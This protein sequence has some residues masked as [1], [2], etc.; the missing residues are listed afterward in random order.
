M[1]QPIVERMLAQRVDG[2]VLA[3]PTPGDFLVDFIV[4]TGL[5]PVM[6]NRADESGR[7]R[8]VVGD[9]WLAMKLVINNLVATG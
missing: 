7:P 9:D 4:A 5:H 1:E 3:T 8:S 2:L 6:V